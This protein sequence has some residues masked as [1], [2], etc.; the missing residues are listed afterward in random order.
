MYLPAPDHTG[1]ETGKDDKK[2]GKDKKEKVK[3]A[4]KIAKVCNGFCF[5]LM[6]LNFIDTQS[7]K[8]QTVW[9]IVVS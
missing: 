8:L 9:F 3:V 5:G 1:T 7:L 4:K 6:P 2:E